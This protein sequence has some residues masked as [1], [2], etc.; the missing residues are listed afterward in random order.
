MNLFKQISELPCIEETVQWAV[1]EHLFQ[2]S[3]GGVCEDFLFEQD[4]K[5]VHKLKNI[6]LDEAF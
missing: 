1:F 6:T 2:F 3:A 5:G 4:I